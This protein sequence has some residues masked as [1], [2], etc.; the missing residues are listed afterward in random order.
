MGEIT[1]QD[2][3]LTRS[4]W[5]TVAKDPETN[6]V[7]LFT[8][9]FTAH[10][11]YATFFYKLKASE[12][13]DLYKSARFR[14]HIAGSLFPAITKMLDNLDHPSELQ[15]QLADVGA[16]HRKRGLK[17][18]HFENLKVVLLRV[19]KKAL[20]TEVFTPEAEAAWE[21]ILT[22]AFSG[23]YGTLEKTEL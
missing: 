10:P 21:K 11:S 19:L 3:Q 16:N 4:I 23:I 12:S 13:D 18:E 7:A 20:G 2:K 8:E 15:T 9:L 14:R 22:A 5:A 1:E 6:G 17:K